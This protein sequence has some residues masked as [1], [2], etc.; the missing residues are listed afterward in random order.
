[1]V[2][3]KS[4]PDLKNEMRVN[5]ALEL[6]KSNMSSK[7]SIEGIGKNAGFA[8]PSNFFLIFKK[9]TGYTPNQWL[10]LNKVE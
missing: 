2:I 8:S 4:F 9:I 3:N 7:I 6:L 10:D 1:M 5:Y